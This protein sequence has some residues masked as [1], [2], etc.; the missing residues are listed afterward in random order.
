MCVFLHIEL[1]SPWDLDLTLRA[2]KA[3][4]WY[5]LWS[6]SWGRAGDAKRP[7]SVTRAKSFCNHVSQNRPHFWPPSS[8]A[9]E[10]WQRRGCRWDWSDQE[11]ADH[12]LWQVWTIGKRFLNLARYKSDMASLQEVVEL[13]TGDLRRWE[14][15]I[16]TG[17]WSIKGGGMMWEED[18]QTLRLC[19]AP[20]GRRCRWGKPKSP[21]CPP[22]RWKGWPWS[23]RRSWWSKTG[24]KTLLQWRK[25]SEG[26]RSSPGRSSFLFWGVFRFFCRVGAARTCHHLLKAG[27]RCYGKLVLYCH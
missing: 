5:V 6:L 19:W 3:V 8:L 21:H 26:W 12:H 25:D 22:S 14:K 7:D 9:G 18:W 1:A 23:R 15:T 20:T 2:E 13:T 10:S 16:N 4:L 24:G 17:W 27:V 11:T